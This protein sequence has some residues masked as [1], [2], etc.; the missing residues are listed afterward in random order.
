MRIQFWGTRGSI[1]KPGP[2]TTKYGGNTS[3]VEV[4][5]DSGTIVVID[6][7][8]GGHGLGFQL[9]SQRAKDASVS[10]H[11]LISHTHWDHIQGIPFFAPMFAQGN[12]WN[13]YGPKGLSHNLRSTLARQMDYSYFPIELDQFAST[14]HY[15][16]LVEGVFAIDDIQ[17]ITRYL[18]HPALTLGY[19]LEAD[20]ASV[21]YCCDH[22]PHS[23][24]FASGE[25]L[26]TGVDRRYADFVEGADL[27]IHDAQYTALEYAAKVGW[28]HST[29]EY[30]VRVCRDAGVKRLLLTHHD[31]MRDDASIDRIVEGVRE[32]LRDT[33][34]NLHVEAAAEGLMIELHGTAIP[35]AQTKKHFQA[36]TAISASSM[37]RSVLLF[38]A[39]PNSTDTLSAAV[40][41]ESMPLVIA[42]SEDDLIKRV[43]EEQFAVVLIEHNPPQ[44]DGLALASAIRREETA[45]KVQVPIVL[46]TSRD[47][48]ASRQNNIATDWLAA[49]FS[50]SYARTKIRAWA[51]RSASRWIR[52]E[53][54]TNEQ[55]R[56]AALHNLAILDTLPEP[57]FDR[58]TRV[59]AAAFG[60]PI[61]LVSLIDVDRQWFKSCYGMNTSE[62]S[63][64]IAFCA[65]VVHQ[66][67]E[68]IVADT[69]RDDR[70]ADNPL[71]LGE[72]HIRFYAGA[73]LT[74]K[75]GN[76]IGTLCLIDTRP[77]ELGSND[78]DMLL[79]LRDLVLEEIERKKN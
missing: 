27:V 66:K 4:R 35:S 71:V 50:L 5:S 61:A 30:A 1:A 42:T 7:G 32:R 15:H 8:T 48:T 53:V 52:A 44:R 12:V 60:V 20:G 40:R 17:V 41:G 65:H 38:T 2:S 55:D 54:P 49:P 58:I 6:C 34:S 28:G 22:E 78:M 73:P 25:L 57:R 16:D 74:L 24:A 64:D 79:D 3:C 67:S 63:R 69:L 72:P 23:A 19:R 43:A 70:F 18:N 26:I 76:C 13:L 21:A 77:R 33:K 46:V 68:L 37:S 45:G 56:L 29:V 62:T 39:T 47:T 75:D 11:M 59:A 9:M 14:N 31:P 10:G 36:R 51:L